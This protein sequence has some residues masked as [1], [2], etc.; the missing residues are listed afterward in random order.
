MVIRSTPDRPGY[1][2]LE[3]TSELA[4][5]ARHGP[6][7]G[8]PIE[9]AADARML[10]LSKPLDALTLT[11]YGYLHVVILLCSRLVQ[12]YSRPLLAACW[13]LQLPGHTVIASQLSG[14]RAIAQLASSSVRASISATVHASLVARVAFSAS[15]FRS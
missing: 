15:P 3:R 1:L 4:K 2:A 10:A 9:V 13:S 12:G 8:S 14:K 7:L 11:T 6:W 5:A